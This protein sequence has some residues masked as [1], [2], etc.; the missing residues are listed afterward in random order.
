M[1]LIQTIF[2][3]VWSLFVAMAPF[4]LLGFAVAGV[5]DTL[6][7][8]RWIERH[9]SGGGLGPIVRGVIVG[10]PLPICSC[11]VIPLAAKLRQQGASPGATAAFTATTPQTGVDSIAA[12]FSLLGGAFTAVRVAANFVGGIFAGLLVDYL[13]RG[14]K[15]A[16]SVTS[17]T[18]DDNDCCGTERSDEE[19]SRGEGSGTGCCGGATDAETAPEA[20][21]PEPGCCSTGQESAAAKGW[22]AKARAALVD[23][24]VTLPRSLGRWIVLGVVLGGLL[25]ALVPAS[26]LSGLMGSPVWVY[27]AVTALSVPLYVCATGSIPMAFALVHAGLSPGVAMVFLIAGP[28]TNTATIATLLRVLG[29]RG[30]AGYL[31]A[32]VAS[33]WVMGAV[34]D[35][36]W[37]TG[38]VVAEA[39]HEGHAGTPLWHH[40]AGVVFLAVLIPGLLPRRR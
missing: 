12:T 33:A 3:E 15:G 37:P 7:P 9:L 36:L 28:A 31:G 39:A 40:V 17:A 18:T 27:L 34:I 20:S 21:A 16:P 2:A 35:V 25:S 23:G 1:G 4:L 19:D 5:A 11:G 6:V 13:T 10:I 29:R 32:I 14:G 8:A 30:T 38:L 22:A 26:S 24:F